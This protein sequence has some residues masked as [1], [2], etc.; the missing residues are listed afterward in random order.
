[1]ITRM[2]REMVDPPTQGTVE[3]IR[4]K[5]GGRRKMA[6]SKKGGKKAAYSAVEEGVINFN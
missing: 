5:K 3:S 1:M 4:G 6:V 2:T